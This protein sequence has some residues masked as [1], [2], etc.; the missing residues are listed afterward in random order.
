MGA[1]VTRIPYTLDIPMMPR[2]YTRCTPDATFDKYVYAGRAD[3][4]RGRT[5]Y[6]IRRGARHIYATI[7]DHV[8][9]SRILAYES[10]GTLFTPCIRESP[11]DAELHTIL[12][13]DALGPW[14]I[15][16]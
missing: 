11:P 1:L 15:R 16:L 6:E 14:G 2:R 9:Q 3:S 4:A 13:A 12:R 7:I 5:H 8:A 10:R